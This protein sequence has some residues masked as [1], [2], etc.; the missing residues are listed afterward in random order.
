[1]KKFEGYY[2]GVNLG[3]W[4]SQ[5]CHEIEHYDTFI[6][7]DDIKE[8]ASWGVDHIRVPMDYNVIETEDG[9]RIE[10]NY[11]YLDRCLEWCEKYHLNM[12]LDLHKTAGYVFDDLEY[13]SGFFQ[14]EALQ[15]RFLKLW[16]DLAARYAEKYADRLV[17]E[18]LNEIVDPNVAKEWNALAKRAMLVIRKYS[19][20]IKILV[21]GINYNNVLSVQLLDPPM[22]ENIVYNFHC[23]DPQIFTHQSAYW[24]DF[25]PEGFHCDYPLTIEEYIKLAKEN[26][27][28]EGSITHFNYPGVTK[29]DSTFF[30]AIF[31]T[32]IAHA[33]KYNVPLYCGEYGVIDQAPLEGTL[34]WYKDIHE[35]FERHQ[36]GRAAWTYKKMD[37][38][39]TQD[40]VAEIKE[41][42]IKYL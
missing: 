3:G 4:I 22:D 26:N 42:L 17:F 10:E 38:G 34:N 12:V 9:E 1:M 11:K 5:C 41:E 19:K 23:Y 13:S 14:D 16:D 32:A 2:R 25:M 33:E 21:G 28:P 35:A 27:F 30:D 40:H 36:I 7:E 29:M 37:F 24:Q 31:A 8:I 6:V 20:D 18:I 15:E 39:L